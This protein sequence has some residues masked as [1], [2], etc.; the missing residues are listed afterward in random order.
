MALLDFFLYLQKGDI[1]MQR[2]VYS[3]NSFFYGKNMAFTKNSS[4]VE[5]T[6]SEINNVYGGNVFSSAIAVYAAGLGITYI[7]APYFLATYI[8][9]TTIYGLAGAA[10]AFVISGG[11]KNKTLLA[12]ADKII[13][14]SVY[15]ALGLVAYRVFK[16]KPNYNIVSALP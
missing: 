1:K 3:K 2:A 16:L 10:S 9:G 15:S 12:F 5:L 6:I 13:A 11:D 8:C 4:V 14:A 7:A